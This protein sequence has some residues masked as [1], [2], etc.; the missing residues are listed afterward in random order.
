M[1]FSINRLSLL[2]CVYPQSKQFFFKAN[3]Q[4]ERVC[5]IVLMV[6]MKIQLQLFMLPKCVAS[7]SAYFF[8][9]AGDESFQLPCPMW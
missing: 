1:K 3:G 7:F 2:G 5:E 4:V 6:L 9:D 8:T